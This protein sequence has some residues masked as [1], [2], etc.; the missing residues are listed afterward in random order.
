M[1]IYIYIYVYNVYIYIINKYVCIIYIY[2]YIYIYIYIYMCPY[3][4][5]HLGGAPA[6]SPRVP[7]PSPPGRFLFLSPAPDPGKYPGRLL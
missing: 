4:V 6:R 3:H 7:P 2:M 5:F 1:C